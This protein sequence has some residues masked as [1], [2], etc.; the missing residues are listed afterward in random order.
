MPSPAQRLFQLITLLQARR[1]WT[2]AALAERLGVDRRSIRR[3]IER[4]RELGYPVQASTG[5]GGGYRLGDGSPV[6]P[7]LLDEDEAT[8]IA[9][10]LRAATASVGGMEDTARR[11]LAKLQPLVP[12]RHRGQAGDL[13]AATS[14]LSEAPAVEVGL[15]G[16]LAHACRTHARLAFDYRS[17]DGVPSRRRVDAQHLVTYLRRWYLLAWDCDRQD[18]RTLRVDRLS[19]L[20]VEAT[21]GLQ[22]RTPQSPEAMVRHAVSRAPFVLSAELLLE[23][24]AEVLAPQVPPWC[25]VLR[26]AGP[27]R[28]VL[29]MGADS[30]A[31]LAGQILSLGRPVLAITTSPP[32]LANTLRAALADVMAV[33]APA[34]EASCPP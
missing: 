9:L 6:L 31:V 20:D 13:H 4:L 18:W 30:P 34:P 23:G 32:E 5:V 24:T 12:A 19:A 16:R 33:L 27:A 29:Q 21:H 2:G 22:R 26:D 1:H 7:L 15:L 11:V 14:N 17:H 28:C 8:A 10:S 3:D 25:G